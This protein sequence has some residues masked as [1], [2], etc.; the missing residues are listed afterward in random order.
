MD[1]FPTLYLIIIFKI[2]FILFEWYMDGII[3]KL[4]GDVGSL[5]ANIKEPL[6]KP[7]LNYR[8]N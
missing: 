6:I 5:K 8:L 4:S 1:Q 7:F 3:Q 2:R